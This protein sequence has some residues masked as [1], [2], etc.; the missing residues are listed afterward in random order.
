MV[1]LASEI[2]RD[3]SNPYDPSSADWKPVKSEIREWGTFVENSQTGGLVSV[4][5]WSQLSA[6]TPS[7][8]RNAGEVLGPDSGTH[9][10][11]VTSLVVSNEGRYSFVS[12]TGWTRI[13]NLTSQTILD[14]IAAIDTKVDN[15]SDEF[16]ATVDQLNSVIES[17]AGTPL[18]H[19]EYADVLTSSKD[20]RPLIYA[21]LD[22]K[23]KIEWEPIWDEEFAWVVR[24]ENDKV[25]LGA[26][27]DGSLYPVSSPEETPIAWTRD[28]CIIAN[29][30]GKRV[31]VTW[32]APSDDTILIPDRLTST[33][34]SWYED[35]GSTLENFEERLVASTQFTTGLTNVALVLCHGQSLMAGSGSDPVTNTSAVSTGKAQMFLAGTLF[36]NDVVDKSDLYDLIDLKETRATENPSCG[37]GKVLSTTTRGTILANSSWGGR[38]WQELSPGSVYWTNLVMASDRARTIAAMNGLPLSVFT[39]VNQ[40]Q[41]N[42]T[43]ARGAYYDLMKQA[44][45]DFTRDIGLGVDYPVFVSQISEWGAYGMATSNVPFD[46]LAVHTTI[47]NM[48]CTGAT[49]WLPRNNDGLHL[50]GVSSTRYG[51]YLGLLISIYL[52]D[53]NPETLVYCKNKSRSGS[54]ITLTFNVS[55]TLDT[56]LVSDPGNY[57][58]Y[59]TQVGGVPQTISS[60]TVSGFTV[61]I[62][63]TGDPGSITAGTVDANGVVSG[64]SYVG[65][66]DRTTTAD[67]ATYALAD[68]DPVRLAT[69]FGP[70][71]GPRTNIRSVSIGNDQFGNPLYRWASHQRVA[72]S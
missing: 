3:K 50:T 35:D 23:A 46:Q 40:G 62:V 64:G 31:N 55:L 71:C 53:S 2:W 37:I 70:K 57:G 65:I 1:K 30:N 54:T 39:V 33:S 34:I 45:I 21:T 44:R 27:H 17:A 68:D 16:D 7:Q 20:G 24:D 19:E 58:F 60:V 18:Y 41:A 22:G 51:N 12:G 36:G 59:W 69:V 11:P 66:A 13:G 26:R 15:L 5:L 9:T 4:K 56:T 63:L 47:D 6:I 8:D 67:L 42:R 10:D 52:A 14:E 49:Y 32:R 61:T 38:T 25:A 48:F 43:D 29:I 28:G 72:I